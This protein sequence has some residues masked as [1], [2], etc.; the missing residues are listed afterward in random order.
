ML[1]VIT[2]VL[3]LTIAQV[4]LTQIETYDIEH[5]INIAVLISVAFINRTLHSRYIL[6]LSWLVS[7]WCLSL[8]LRL[9]KMDGPIH[10]L[11]AET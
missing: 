3:V 1:V 4:E 2:L 8:N 11:I 6:V 10:A 9:M 5:N 7:I